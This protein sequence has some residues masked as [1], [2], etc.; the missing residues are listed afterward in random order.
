MDSQISVK[1]LEQKPFVL[2]VQKLDQVFEG[3][4]RQECIDQMLK[5]LKRK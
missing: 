3:W 1:A 5:A 2:W 4:T